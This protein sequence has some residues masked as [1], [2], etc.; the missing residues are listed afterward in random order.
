LRFSTIFQEL[1][2]KKTWPI[3]SSLLL[4]GAA[5]CVNL[6]QAQGASPSGSSSS[7]GMAAPPP[8]AAQ[9]ASAAGI[10]DSDFVDAAARSGMMEVETSKIAAKRT[11][12]AKVKSF[13]R[14]MASDHAEANGQLKKLAQNK[15]ITL[16]DKQ[17]VMSE[18]TS[19]GDKKGNDFDIAYMQVA[20]ADAHQKAVSLFEQESSSGQD[21]QLRAFAKATLPTLKKHLKEAQAIE[22][23]LEGK[24]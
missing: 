8:P 22:T 2:L 7:P 15:G 19:L 12:N 11:S 13:A 10:H 5:L 17:E 1:K 16:P 24:K 14:M 6:A 20:G 9:G 21:A 4:A 23:S 3:V 18:A